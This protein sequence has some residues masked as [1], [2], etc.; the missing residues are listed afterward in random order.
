MKTKR[1]PL[2]RK[3]KAVSEQ[4]H[5]LMIKSILM[6]EYH[7]INEDYFDVVVGF[8]LKVFN[9]EWINGESSRESRNK[10]NR[11]SLVLY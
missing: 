2:Y 1:A 8:K 7:P 11:S 10:S 3:R 5:L 4:T 9:R 6:Y